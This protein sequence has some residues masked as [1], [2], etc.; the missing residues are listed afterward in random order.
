LGVGINGYTY[1]FAKSV[2]SGI[3]FGL[4]VYCMEGKGE[5]GYGNP[6]G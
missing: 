6:F 3:L 4:E 5:V 1:G 2:V